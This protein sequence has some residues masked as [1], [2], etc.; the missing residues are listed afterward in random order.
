MSET[1]NLKLHLTDDSTEKFID[2]RNKMNGVEDSNMVKIDDAIGDIRS[3]VG[4]IDATILDK[5]DHST[6]IDC[7]LLASAWVD[8][9][10][11]IAV[12]G[13]N[14]DV[15]GVI[16][17]ARGISDEQR[18]AAGRAALYV[19]KQSENTLTIAVG[20]EVPEIDIDATI[21]LFD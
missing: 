16:G 6:T 18:I 20:G 3:A 21:I 12:A 10:Q 14:E 17:V 2:W 5:A 7:T 19:S 13:I 8:G 15:N 9:A 4:D 11:D 1:K